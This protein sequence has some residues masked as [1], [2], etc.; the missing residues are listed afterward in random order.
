MCDAV[1]S[2]RTLRIFRVDFICSR[3]LFSIKLMFYKTFVVA[4]RNQTYRV[5]YILGKKKNNKTRN[6]FPRARWGSDGQLFVLF[7][8][9]CWHIRRL[10]VSVYDKKVS[11]RRFKYI[12]TRVFRPVQHP[13]RSRRAPHKRTYCVCVCVCVYIYVHVLWVLC[14]PEVEVSGNGNRFR[15]SLFPVPF[16]F[17][18]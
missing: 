4:T 14:R 3:G 10:C 15:S 16:P 2:F 11:W 12:V 8:L 7:S 6:T 13:Q 9:L 18:S 1:C 17:P 5:P